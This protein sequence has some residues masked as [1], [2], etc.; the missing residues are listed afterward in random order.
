MT[1]IAI[2]WYYAEHE[3]AVHD[4]AEVNHPS[5]PHPLCAWMEELQK[6][7]DARWVYSI[8]IPDIQSRDENGFPKRLRSLAN[9]IVHTREEAVAAVEEAI[10]RIVSG[11][12]LVS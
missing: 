11:P 12:V 7:P 6:C 3:F 1:T 4:A 2:D 8:D 10:R 9:G 5:Y